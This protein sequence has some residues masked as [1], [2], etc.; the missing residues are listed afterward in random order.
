MH[1]EFQVHKDFTK[2]T[3]RPMFHVQHMVAVHHVGKGK[4]DERHWEHE[5]ADDGVDDGHKEHLQL[6]PI[7]PPIAKVV[8]CNL[9]RFLALG[10]R[11]CGRQVVIDVDIDNSMQ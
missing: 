2:T 10:P 5:W 3:L 4:V 7:L 6:D 8:H 1:M 11:F 9:H